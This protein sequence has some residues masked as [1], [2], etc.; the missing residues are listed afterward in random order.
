[1]F[2][3][4]ALGHAERMPHLPPPAPTRPGRVRRRVRGLDRLH[5]PAAPRAGGIDAASPAATRSGGAS[6]PTTPPPRWRCCRSSSPG[7]PSRSRSATSRSRSGHVGDRR[8]EQ[9]VERSADAGDE[10]V[11]AEIPTRQGSLTPGIGRRRRR[12]RRVRSRSATLGVLFATTTAI[13]W[14]GQFVVGK[15]ALESVNAFPLS[16]VRYALAA[17]LWLVVLA[18]VEGP[19]ALRLGGRGWRLFWLGSLGFAG[20]NLL[21]YTG[22]AHA[23]PETASLIVALGPLLTALVLWRRT[24][25]RPARGDVRPARGRAARGRA[26]RQRRSPQLDRARGDR[27]G[28]GARARGRVQLRALRPRRRR[29]RRVLA[30]PLHRADGRARVADDRRRHGRRDRD[31]ARRAGP[32]PASSGPSRRRSCTSRSP[33]RSS[34]S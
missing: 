17:A 22:L 8:H 5:E 18:V 15:S 34:P 23:R 6:R 7:A 25:R 13:V 14:G 2:R 31:G 27:L 19:G 9:S 28:R 30:A 32:P 33:A 21:A 1:M 10:P 20:F 16:T 12:G 24:G 26:R 29:V 11:E 3:R 4:P